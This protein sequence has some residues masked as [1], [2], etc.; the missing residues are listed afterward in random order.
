MWGR[1][2][3]LAMKRIHARVGIAGVVKLHPRRR[4]RQPQLLVQAFVHHQ[5]RAPRHPIYAHA[6]VPMCPQ[7][8]APGPALGVT[9]PLVLHRERAAVRDTVTLPNHQRGRVHPCGTSTSNAT[10]T[11]RTST[12][13]SRPSTFTVNVLGWYTGVSPRANQRAVRI[14]I[15]PLSE[16]GAGGPRVAAHRFRRARSRR[17]PYRPRRL[18][19]HDADGLHQRRHLIPRLELLPYPFPHRPT[20]QLMDGFLYLVWR[21]L[22]LWAFDIYDG[23]I[24]NADHGNLLVDDVTTKHE[25]R[26]VQV[27]FLFIETLRTVLPSRNQ[28]PDHAV[29]LLRPRRDHGE[30]GSDLGRGHRAFAPRCRRPQQAT[31]VVSCWLPFH[32]ALSMTT[33]NVL[34][35][36]PA[37][38]VDGCSPSY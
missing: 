8:P 3:P 37:R 20:Q 12:H 5:V 1:G 9:A 22:H 18:S 10:A 16:C 4:G 11:S 25:Q 27:G 15:C 7:R 19:R 29:R 23:V 32:Q 26:A 31:I 38:L 34:N 36:L 30:R 28:F 35:V 17:D 13:R 2:Y 21:A 33:W 14:F 6:A 24:H